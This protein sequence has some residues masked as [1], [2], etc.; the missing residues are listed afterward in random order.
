MIEGKLEIST[1][2]ANDSVIAQ[3]TQVIRDWSSDY[4]KVRRYGW[5]KILPNQTVFF[6]SLPIEIT[7][8][9]K[10]DLYFRLSQIDGLSFV[11]NTFN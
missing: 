5:M 11:C 9:M 2:C 3:A 10:A 4:K 6:I 8:A 7:E 1:F